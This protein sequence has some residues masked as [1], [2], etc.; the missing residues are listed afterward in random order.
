MQQT[1]HEKLVYM[2]VY[3]V[4]KGVGL[5]VPQTVGLVCNV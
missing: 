5:L 3:M 2:Y 4:K 1:N